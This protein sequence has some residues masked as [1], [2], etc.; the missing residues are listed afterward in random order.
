MITVTLVALGLAIVNGILG[1]LG[2]ISSLFEALPALTN[3]INWLLTAFM[4][5]GGII[6][7][8]VLFDVII[9]LLAFLEGL[10]MWKFL[11]I[12]IGWIPIIGNYIRDPLRII[13]D[14]LT[15]HTSSQPAAYDDFTERAGYGGRYTENVPA[16]E[17]RKWYKR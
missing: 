7:I 4:Y 6:N 9:F 17:V 3:T 12:V 14:E 16:S 2:T 13:N 10:I 1:I 8:P 15:A 5:F 11:F